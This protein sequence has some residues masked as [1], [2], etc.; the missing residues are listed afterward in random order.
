MDH[1]NIC[2][3]RRQVRRDANPQ[4]LYRDNVDPTLYGKVPEAALLRAELNKIDAIGLA[5]PH[6]KQIAHALVNTPLPDAVDPHHASPIPHDAGGSYAGHQ[7]G[8]KA[9]F[10]ADANYDDRGGGG[11]GGRQDQVVWDGIRRQRRRPRPRPK[12]PVQRHR[13]Q[14]LRPQFR[15]VE[16]TKGPDSL[17]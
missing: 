5:D 8:K 15:S 10:R 4:E 7:P 14:Q 17:N 11:G 2:L 13:P 3:F 6:A 9:A 1:D 12:P 16:N